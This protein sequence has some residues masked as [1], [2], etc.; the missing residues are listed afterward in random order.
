MCP[1]TPATK[2][3]VDKAVAEALANKDYTRNVSDNGP[4]VK[5][6]VPVLNPKSV[7]VFLKEVKVGISLPAETVMRTRR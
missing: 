2:A 5:I 7:D 3:W 4:K 1:L 6:D